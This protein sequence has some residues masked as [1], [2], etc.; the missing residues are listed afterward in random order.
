MKYWYLA[1]L[2]IYIYHFSGAVIGRPFEGPSYSL[3]INDNLLHSGVQNLEK[4]Y[5]QDP[6]NHNCIEGLREHVVESSDCPVGSVNMLFKE[7]GT[8]TPINQQTNKKRKDMHQDHSSTPGLESRTRCRNSI[9]ADSNIQEI[10]LFG[11]IIKI[12]PA[13]KLDIRKV[14]THRVNRLCV[15]YARYLVKEF[16]SK[17]RQ[18]VDKLLSPQNLLES[19]K[20]YKD[21]LFA[22]FVYFMMLRGLPKVVWDR[23]QILSSFIIAEFYKLESKEGKAVESSKIYKFILWHTEM[24][25]H[26]TNPKLLEHI[27]KKEAIFLENSNEGIPQGTSPISKFL[28]ALANGVRFGNFCD[29]SSRVSEWAALYL[30]NYWVRDYHSDYPGV[31]DPNTPPTSMTQEWDRISKIILDLHSSREQHE[32]NF[33]LDKMTINEPIIGANPFILSMKTL[34]DDVDF[35]PDIRDIEGQSY[36]L[37]IRQDLLD[38]QDSNIYQGL[39][40]WMDLHAKGVLSF[41][42][43]FCVTSVFNFLESRNPGVDLNLFWKNMQTHEKRRRYYCTKSLMTHAKSRKAGRPLSGKR[44]K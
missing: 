44:S 27:N 2:K 26:L 29:K 28:S 36:Q 40:V 35:N 42:D 5:L 6:T 18:R 41:S 37:K 9:Q 14:S 43:P 24:T 16:T 30:Q 38:I 3:N 32:F 21:S 22:P 23:V 31:P 34:E 10:S 7:Q 1:I 13:Y 39:G 8:Q 17:V 11:N 33:L 12:E 15:Y 4:P 25:Y 20:Q 19:Y